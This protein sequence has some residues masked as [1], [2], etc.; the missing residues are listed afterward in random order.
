M[1]FLASF[2]VALVTLANTIVPQ[3]NLPKVL[4]VETTA[5]APS[6]SSS[7]VVASQYKT[8]R[9]AKEQEFNVKLQTLKDEKKKAVVRNLED[10]LQDRGQKWCTHWS[11]VTAR[12]DNLMVRVISRRDK[13]KA[14]GKDTTA[15]D[16]AIA[17]AQ[18]A[19]SAAKT[20]GTAQCAKTYTIQITSGDSGIGQDVKTA[21]QAFSTDIKSVI[22]TMEAAR[23]AIGGAISA[24]KGINGVDGDSLATP[25]ATTTA[26][27]GGIAR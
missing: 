6:A 2:F 24:L 19:I 13:A 1:E 25:F 4:G 15:A 20:A 3:A 27:Q 22:S 11:E 17:S 8:A 14:A 21:V 10:I 16:S 18:S 9:A 7:S 26:T 23:K 12:M 5:T